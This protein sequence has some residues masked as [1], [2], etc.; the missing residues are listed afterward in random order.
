MMTL[1]SLK[2]IRLGS[3]VAE[4]DQ[5][6]D[7]YF[8]E[9]ETFTRLVSD[10]TDTIS[11]DK[12]TGKTALF[13]ILSKRYPTII[14]LDSVEIVPA[15]N[16]E[17][18]PVFQRLNE[19]EVLTEGQ[20]QTPWKS[21]FF[22]LGANWLLGMWDASEWTDPMRELNNLLERTGLSTADDSPSTVFSSIVNLFRRL[23]HPKSAEMAMTIG[24]H[25]MPVVVPRIEFD[26]ETAETTPS[27]VPHEEAFSSA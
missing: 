27:Y 2:A 24:P 4:F 1:E 12:G 26:T 25:G 5:Y 10:D 20:Y 9:T 8:V 22:S 14:S 16:V 11:G 23:L 15:F 3:S 17:G 13:R 6:L 7:D 19:G 21:Y 18:T